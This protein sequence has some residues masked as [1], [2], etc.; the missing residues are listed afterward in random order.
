ML[1]LQ[2]YWKNNYKD[3]HGLY[4]YE[5]GRLQKVV[6]HND[7]FQFHDERTVMILIKHV[8]HYKIQMYNFVYSIFIQNYILYC[9]HNLRDHFILF[10]LV[11]IIKK[12]K[13]CTKIFIRKF[14]QA[15]DY[16]MDEDIDIERLKLKLLYLALRF[17][18]TFKS[19]FHNYR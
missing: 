1:V 6:C 16:V 7:R 17:T 12:T 15:V 4:T 2:G 14:F 5:D 13:I 10:Y 11:N 3:G 9:F 8:S 19:V 18:N